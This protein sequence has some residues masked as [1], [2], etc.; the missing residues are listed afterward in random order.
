VAGPEIQTV[1][2]MLRANPP[3]QG[4]NVLEM[5]A[6]MDA[7]TAGLPRPE[8]VRFEPLQVG[9]LAG[10]WTVA[11]GAD[12]DRAVL[13]LH[14]GGYG[15]GSIA[16]HRATVAALSRAA[17]MGVLNLGY[18][19]APEHPFPAAVED[20]VAGFRFLLSRGLDAS[21]LAV[22]GDSAG[23]GLTAATLLALRDKGGPLPGAAVLISPWLDLTQS[24]ESYRTRAEQDPLVKKSMLDEMARSYL[25]GADPTDPLAS[26]LFGNLA[27]LPP[28][29]IQVGTAEVL[30]DDSRRFVERARAAGADVEIETWEDMVHVWHAFALILPE[31]REAIESIG[32]FLRRR[33]A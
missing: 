28:L 6:A 27:G 24:G 1:V 26:P 25:A 18:R 2:Q 20:A 11:E 10:E 3:I 13:Y 32:I 22:A 12:P 14:G 33:L 29:L 4:S 9:E 16:S 15:I 8:G 7:M 21:R 19:L 17:R 31:A 5:R 30:L 23:G